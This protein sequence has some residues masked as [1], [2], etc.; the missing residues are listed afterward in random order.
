MTKW[1]F[2]KFYGKFVVRVQFTDPITYP[3]R[4]VALRTQMSKDTVAFRI[5][6]P[7]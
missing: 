3:K 7:F 5:D 1:Y 4:D 6:N 2:E